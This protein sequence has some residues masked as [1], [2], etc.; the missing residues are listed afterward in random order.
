M[1]AIFAICVALVILVIIGAAAIIFSI[2]TGESPG[3]D[4]SNAVIN[5]RIGTLP[6]SQKDLGNGIVDE[7]YVYTVGNPI[8]F[9]AHKGWVHI[10]NDGTLTQEEIKAMVT[11]KVREE[12]I[13]A[14]WNRNDLNIVWR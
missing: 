9:S 1:G 13:A 2:I 5:V 12:V 14:G 4:T 3:L 11:P 7:S 6:Y 10:N 8:F